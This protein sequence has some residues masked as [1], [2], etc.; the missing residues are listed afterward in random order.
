[1]PE[2]LSLIILLPLFFI[3]RDIQAQCSSV[4]MAFQTGEEIEYL[5]YYNWKFIWLNAASVNFSVKE[6]T[7]KNQPVYHF[8]STG[9]SHKTYDLFFKV[10]DRFE[11]YVEK[12]SFRPLWFERDTY[13]GGY[14]AN[15][16]YTWNYDKKQAILRTINSEHPF[17]T[18]TV[19][20]SGCSFDVLSAIYYCRNIDFS[21]YKPG[22][23][24]PITMII[25]DG[26]YNLYIRYMGKEIAET[27]DKD[28]YDCIKFSVAL[29]EGTIFKEGEDLFV[30]VTNDKNRLPII[31]EAKILIGSVKAVF[32]SAKNL[33]YPMT[34]KLN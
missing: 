7:Y 15:D 21:K 5:A 34:A 12:E 11:S 17:K 13:E 9:K 26:V 1:M 25:D 20:L 6:K 2:K 16:V 23:K 28:K 14:A 31:V 30:W 4:N 3:F 24:I 29:V 33:R 8:L 19:Q 27:R 10:R 22:D 32:Q 18:D